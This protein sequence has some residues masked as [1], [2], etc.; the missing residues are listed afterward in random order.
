MSLNGIIGKWF[1]SMDKSPDFQGCVKWQ[2]KVLSKINDGLY[3]VQLFEWM[4]GQPTEQKLVSLNEMSDW[5]FYDSSENMNIIYN[6]HYKDKTTIALKKLDSKAEFNKA[7][8]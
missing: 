4:A 8:K 1:H 2:G 5:I 3:L 7:V 6:D